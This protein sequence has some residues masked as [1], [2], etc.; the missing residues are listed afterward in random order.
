MIIK[1]IILNIKPNMFKQVFNSD[2]LKGITIM[3]QL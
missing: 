2:S 3:K 1:I